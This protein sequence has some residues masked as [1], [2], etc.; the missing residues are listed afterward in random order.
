MRRPPPFCSL[1]SRAERCY[2]D[3]SAATC[4]ADDEIFRAE[5]RPISAEINSPNGMQSTRKFRDEKARVIGAGCAEDPVRLRQNPA[6]RSGGS[7]QA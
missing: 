1:F 3:F 2:T 4:E 5:I 6:V 7:R